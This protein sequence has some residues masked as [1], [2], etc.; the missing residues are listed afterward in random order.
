MD[1]NGIGVICLL[2]PHGKMLLSIS[3]L[4]RGICGIFF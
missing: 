2:C 1:N 4:R 3:S